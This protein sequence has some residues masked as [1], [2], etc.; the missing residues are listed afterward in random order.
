MENI[1]KYKNDK[2]KLNLKKK[3]VSDAYD[4]GTPFETLAI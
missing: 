1:S 4:L 3:T 2:R